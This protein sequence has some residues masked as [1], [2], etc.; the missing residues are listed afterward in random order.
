MAKVKMIK[1]DAVIQV[2]IGAGFMQKL[3]TMLMNITANLSLDDIKRYKEM[4]DNKEA[5]TENWMEDITV[6][7]MLL[8]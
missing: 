3:Q 8:E 1:N 7:T 6:L 2:G 4:V 5:F